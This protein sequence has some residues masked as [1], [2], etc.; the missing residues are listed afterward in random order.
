MSKEWISKIPGLSSLGDTPSPFFRWLEDRE[1]NGGVEGSAEG[2]DSP[3]CMLRSSLEYS[4]YPTSN[5]KK[6]QSSEIKRSETTR[7]Y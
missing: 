5:A 7:F 6:I 1:L 2:K 4:T 3:F